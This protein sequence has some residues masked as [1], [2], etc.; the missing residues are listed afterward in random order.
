V[1]GE[2]RLRGQVELCLYRPG[3]A[4]RGIEPLAE[5]L[6]QAHRQ[7]LGTPFEVV[8]GPQSSMWRDTNVFNELGIP[9]A[10]YGPGAGR[11]G[12]NV[13]VELDE[14]HRAAH[15]YALTAVELCNRR[16]PQA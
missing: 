4:A 14:L 13:G 7:V 12:G 6:E 5:A 10:N 1:L 15:V 3:Y 2:L 11:G 8:S 16:K 9:A